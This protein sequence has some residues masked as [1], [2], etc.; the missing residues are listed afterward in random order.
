MKLILT[1]Q[2][3]GLGEPGDVVVVKDGYG[4]NFLVPN[5][6]ATPWTKGGEKQVEQIRRARGA[7]EVRDLDHAMELKSIL[8]N[9][10]VRL[11]VRAG[12]AGRLFG[13][14]TLT[15]IVEAMAAKGAKVDK[16]RI[17]IASPI[18]TLGDH[19]VT[20]GVHPQVSATVTL[21]VVASK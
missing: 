4:R 10:K 7:R 21:E 6:L 13:S 3:D 2:V 14:V 5:R 19:T 20:V 18:K 8:E 17:Q 12:E 16:R 11:Q 9:G 1:H 15:D